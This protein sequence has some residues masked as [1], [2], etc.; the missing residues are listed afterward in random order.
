MKIEDAKKAK[1]L[2]EEYEF[3]QYLKRVVED[4]YDSKISAEISSQHNFNSKIG[5]R[6]TLNLPIGIQSQ[7]KGYILTRIQE[8]GYLIDQL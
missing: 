2:V 4:N 6:K 3:L 8:L 5:I 7:I 1:E